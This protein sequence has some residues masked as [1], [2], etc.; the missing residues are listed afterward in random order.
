MR[1][2]AV[3]VETLGSIWFIDEIEG[4]YIRMPREEGPRRPGPNGE[5]WGGADAD[6]GLQDLVWHKQYGWEI[7][8]GEAISRLVI[9]T[10]PEHEYVV[11]APLI[12]EGAMP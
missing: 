11:T 4:E 8:P 3:R 2:G 6:P 5:D 12:P 10:D 7:R 9:F 1:P